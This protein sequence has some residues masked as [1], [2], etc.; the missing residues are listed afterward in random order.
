[1]YSGAELAEVASNAIG[2]PIE[3]E[4]ISE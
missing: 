4:N 2:S 1:L 3:F